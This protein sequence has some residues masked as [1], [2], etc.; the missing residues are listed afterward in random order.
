MP[1]SV[2]DGIERLEGMSMAAATAVAKLGKKQATD[3][4]GVEGMLMQASMGTAKFQKAVSDKTEG[5]ESMLLS[6]AHKVAKLAVSARANVEKRVDAVG[7]AT[8]DEPPPPPPPGIADRL[9]RTFDPSAFF[10][11]E[12]SDAEE[13]SGIDAEV[14]PPPS[15]GIANRLQR[16][17]DPSAFDSEDEDEQPSSDSWG[18]SSPV[19]GSVPA[20]S[21]L[22]STLSAPEKAAATVAASARAE[23]GVWRRRAE[24]AEQELRRVIDQHARQH[25]HQQDVQDMVA[26]AERRLLEAAAAQA[27]RDADRLSEETRSVSTEIQHWRERAAAAERQLL[28]ASS[29]SS[30]SSVSVQ[31]LPSSAASVAAAATQSRLHAPGS[32]PRV[33]AAG[34]GAAPLGWTPRSSPYTYAPVAMGPP[35]ASPYMPTTRP[36]PASPY[37]SHMPHPSSSAA[38]PSHLSLAGRAAMAAASATPSAAAASVHQGLEQSWLAECGRAYA[39]IDQACQALLA[40][41]GD[42]E[43][44]AVAAVEQRA[45]AGSNNSLDLRRAVSAVVDRTRA[46]HGRAVSWAQRCFN[47]LLDRL[48]K[49]E[50]ATA[51]RIRAGEAS[52]DR[53]AADRHI[54]G[55]HGE[56]YARL[57]AV[58][59]AIT[60]AIQSQLE[61]V[62]LSPPTAAAAAAAGLPRCEAEAGRLLADALS[63]AEVSGLRLG[64]PSTRSDSSRGHTLAY[65]SGTSSPPRRA[66]SVVPTYLGGG[67]GA[68][69]GGHLSTSSAWQP[70]PRRV[71]SAM[72]LH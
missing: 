38:S 8:Q 6:Q 18:V 62:L 54:Y 33:S 3:Q 32:P 55:R 65:N 49:R 57:R 4:E 30:A 14:P 69:T 26:P 52:A 70:Q 44:A 11:D 21:V 63:A 47:A 46:Q 31:R 22:A 64:L 67:G 20:T 5:I 48:A 7:T 34:T 35:P 51:A 29:A 45:A 15:A 9:T 23:M 19:A 71:A 13:H 43:A 53:N 56:A 16:S 27:D 10:D 12:D 60:A 61:R 2:G 24:Q 59:A 17:F 1:L 50:T 42:L 66:A 58:A 41:I 68:G 40:W 36:P 37:R 28:R 39:T 72:P 25:H